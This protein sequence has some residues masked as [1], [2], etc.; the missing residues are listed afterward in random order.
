MFHDTASALFGVEGLQVA[1]VQAGPGGA[2]EVWAVTDWPTAAACPDCGTVSS[3]P[4][5][6]VMTR[7]LDVRRA[8]D[9][10]DL[11]WVKRRWKCAAEACGRKTFTE[12]VPAVPPRCRITGRLREQAGSEVADRGITPAEAARHAGISWPSAHEA[13]TA[14]AD[15][16][17]DQPVALV[18]HLGI[19]EHRRGRPRWR[20]R[21]ET[22]EYV[23]LADRR[24]EGTLSNQ[25]ATR[26]RLTS[27]TQITS[28]SDT[29]RVINP[30]PVSAPRSG[31]ARGR[32]CC[33]A[34]RAGPQAA[35]PRPASPRRSYPLH[36]LWNWR[37]CMTKCNGSGFR[38]DRVAR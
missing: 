3:R 21:D 38:D 29:G 37:L 9:P 2:V 35:V 7:P 11:R 14:A 31:T 13:F 36:G 10:V 30:D 32:R 15:P 28:V 23:Q 4:H 8:G 22:G 17:L 34:A 33:S 20:R 19:D 25:P 5:E 12:W 24:K 6:T 18:A 26:S 27:K 16:L 1:D